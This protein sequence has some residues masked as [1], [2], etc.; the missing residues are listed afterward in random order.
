MKPIFDLD[1]IK[2][3]ADGATFQKAVKLYEGKKATGFTADE[4][5]CSA[6]A[7]G[8]RF[9]AVNAGVIHPPSP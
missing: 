7:F 1:K 8:S 6:K 3:A 4:F 5:G 9:I 2:F